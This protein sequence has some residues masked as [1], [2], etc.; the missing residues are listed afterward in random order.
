ME[1]LD[2]SSDDVLVRND[3][4]GFFFSFFIRFCEECGLEK[5]YMHPFLTIS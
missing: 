3:K 4:A 5:I 1:I 2:S